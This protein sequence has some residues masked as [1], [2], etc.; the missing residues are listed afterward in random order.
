MVDDCDC[1]NEENLKLRLQSMRVDADN[2]RLNWQDHREVVE[3]DM[4]C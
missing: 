4:H 2:T 3:V 1:S